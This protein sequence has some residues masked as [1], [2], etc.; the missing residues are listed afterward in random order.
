MHHGGTQFN[1]IAKVYTQTLSL[2]TLFS[3]LHFHIQD[4]ECSKHNWASLI[5]ALDDTQ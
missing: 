2:E 4:A 1:Y 5:K 3:K